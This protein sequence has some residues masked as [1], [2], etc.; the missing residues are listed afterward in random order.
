MKRPACRTAVPGR[1]RA[2]YAR[3]DRSQASV[4]PQSLSNAASVFNQLAALGV[5]IRS[6]LDESKAAVSGRIAAPGR[7]DHIRCIG[8][9]DCKSILRNQG[10]PDLRF[11]HRGLQFRFIPRQK[12]PC[13]CQGNR[14]KI[15]YRQG[16]SR[17]HVL[18]VQ[19]PPAA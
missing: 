2:V 4:G 13:I 18:P 19:L 1:H 17:S 6:F 9:G 12:N 16:R 15:H 7:D 14:G 5:P 3:Q 10:F 11:R 8:Q